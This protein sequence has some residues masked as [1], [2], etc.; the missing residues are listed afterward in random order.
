[1]SLTNP[2]LTIPQGGLTS[3]LT[4]F[5]ESRNCQ[6]QACGWFFAMAGGLTATMSA[7]DRTGNEQNSAVVASAEH[8]CADSTT[9]FHSCLQSTGCFR[10]QCLRSANINDTPHPTKKE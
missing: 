10:V 6:P 1:M 7:G 2:T 5:S 8:V 9:F 4:I 3:G